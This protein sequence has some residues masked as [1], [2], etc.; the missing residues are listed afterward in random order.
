MANSKARDIDLGDW[1]LDELKALQKNVGKA[2]ENFEA[3]RKSE[4]IAQLEAKAK[5]MGFS[6][7]ELTG[8]ATG[9]KT[10]KA[11]E[12]KYQHPENASVTWSGRGRRP[13]WIKDAIAKGQTLASYL[14]GK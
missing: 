6:L 14:I 11:A 9:P 7:A 13:Q 5:E 1:S 2:V 4:A 8:I 3:R 10:R 12:A